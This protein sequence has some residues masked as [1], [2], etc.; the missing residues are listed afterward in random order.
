MVARSRLAIVLLL[1]SRVAVLNLSRR[2]RLF[3]VTHGRRRRLNY[4]RTETRQVLSVRKRE[5]RI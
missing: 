2:R 1:T 3:L 5:T 4:G